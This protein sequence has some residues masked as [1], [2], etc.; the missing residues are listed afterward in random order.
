MTNNIEEK[1]VQLPEEKQKEFEERFINVCGN[2]VWLTVLH[3]FS[4][5]NYEK[6]RWQIRETLYREEYVQ[7]APKPE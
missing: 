1:I 5:R 2:E 6:F 7:F 3:N 4:Y